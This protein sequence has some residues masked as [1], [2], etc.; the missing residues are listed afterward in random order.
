MMV[1]AMLV[2]MLFVMVLMRVGF[3]TVIVAM[4]FAKLRIM[5]MMVPVF[6]VMMPLMF[7]G[8]FMAAAAIAEKI[9]HIVVVVVMLKNHVEVADID[10]AFLHAAYFSFEPFKRH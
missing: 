1:F 3:I 7:V 2:V 8:V 6:V 9:R 5:L 10:S 4:L